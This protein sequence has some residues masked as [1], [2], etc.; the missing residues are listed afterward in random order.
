MMPQTGLAGVEH[1]TQQAARP[2]QGL[3]ALVRHETIGN[4]EPYSREQLYSFFFFFL[5]QIFSS[6]RMCGIRIKVQG[7]ELLLS[8]SG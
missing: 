2:P 5:R 8:L 3:S 7:A 1:V 6:E 4:N